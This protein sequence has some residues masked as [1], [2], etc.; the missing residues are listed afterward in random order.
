MA[1]VSVTSDWRAMKTAEDVLARL[2]QGADYPAMDIAQRRA[3]RRSWV[4]GEMMI[5]HPEMTS[6]EVEGLLDRLDL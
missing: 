4:R 1:E 2:K 3:Q 5:E 6:E